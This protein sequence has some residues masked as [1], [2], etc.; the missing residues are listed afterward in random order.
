MYFQN[1]LQVV[2]GQIVGDIAVAEN[3]KFEFK[4]KIEK[5]LVGC[6]LTKFIKIRYF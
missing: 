1:S 5:E 2:L 4:R 6:V 3:L